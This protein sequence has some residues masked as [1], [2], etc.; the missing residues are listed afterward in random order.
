MRLW[1]SVL[2]VAVAGTAP[3]AE[4]EAVTNELAKQEKAGYGG[5]CGVLVDRATGHLFLN[6]S[7]RGLY[8]STDS[9]KTWKPFAPPFKGRTEWPGCLLLDPTGKSNKLLSALVYGSPALIGSIKGEG[10]T[11][12]DRKSSHVDWCSLDWTDPEMKFQIALKHESGGVLLLSRD[13]GKSFIETARGYGPAWVFDSKTAVVAELKSK[14]KQQPGL[15]RT[16]DAG[17]TWKPCGDW[18][19]QALPKW[20][21]NTLFWLV[22]GA[23]IATTDR[24]ESW[25]KLS[26]IKDGKYG[27]IFGKESTQMFVL[28]PGGVIESTDGGATWSKPTPLPKELKGWSPL[29]WLEYDPIHDQ[30]YVMKM[31]SELYRLRRQ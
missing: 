23:L 28:T 25:K 1:L 8:R 9:G 4:W 13:G 10:W 24:G 12:L 31:G 7:D 27:P 2:I 14:E 26:T 22:D 16:T 19:T 29:T 3:S 11:P 21:G 17:M 5:L 30:L 6:I 15:L 20:R 18:I